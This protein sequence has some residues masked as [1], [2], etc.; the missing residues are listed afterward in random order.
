MLEISLDV[1]GYPIVLC[2]TA[3]LRLSEDPIES[4][5]LKRAR[6]AAADA[7]IVLMVVDAQQLPANF[8]SLSLDRFFADECRRLNVAISWVFHTFRKS[9]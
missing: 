9:R 4:E 8:A 5:G 3:G 7:D 2:D 1:G 6:A